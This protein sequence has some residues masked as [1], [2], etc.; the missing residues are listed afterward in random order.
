MD[1]HTPCER[2]PWEEF[3]PRVCRM[4]RSFDGFLVIH[5]DY[6]VSV[7]TLCLSHRGRQQAQCVKV[8]LLPDGFTND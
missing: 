4:R 5:S 6:S 1:T 2:D 7:Q 8:C 3:R